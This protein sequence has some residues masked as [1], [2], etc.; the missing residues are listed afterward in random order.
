MF[1]I[2][3]P[4]ELSLNTQVTLS[5]TAAQHCIKVLRLRTNDLVILFHGDGLSFKSIL[6][7]DG[8][9]AFATPIELIEQDVESP[10]K[11][12]LGQGLA[13]NDRMD[14]I[15]QKAVECGVTEITPLMMDKS[16]VKIK[17][18]R[19]T[20]KQA[21]WQSIITSA[22]EQSGRNTIPLIH[23]P[24]RLDEWLSRPFEGSTIVFDPRSKTSVKN[25]QPA[26][27]IKVLLG[28]EGGFSSPEE[29]LVNKHSILSCHLGPR[30]L[31][32]ET[33][34]IAALTSLQTHFGDI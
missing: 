5:V 7:V 17:Q 31:R 34:T 4:Q 32:T 23:P 8:K 22:C 13:R 21:H 11:I 26:S 18:D 19:L 6:K 1:R 10:L 33:A 15:I 14:W 16:L 30:I 20:Q 9:K 25:L 28:P 2:Y 29:H 27:N 24:Q 12:H 3:H